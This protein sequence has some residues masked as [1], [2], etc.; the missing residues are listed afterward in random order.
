SLI[1]CGITFVGAVLMTFV[2]GVPYIITV[3]I[4]AFGYGGPS[5]INAAVTTDL[6]GAKNSGT[7]YGIVMMGLGVS[8]I[9]FNFISQK[10]LRGDAAAGFIMGA[11]TAVL[12]A[13]T[14]LVISPRLK[15][16]Q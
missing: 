8:S 12:A 9:V 16:E 2:A 5:A 13:V 14:M 4:I 7:N 6:F 11:G 3:A 15:K 10:L 1:L